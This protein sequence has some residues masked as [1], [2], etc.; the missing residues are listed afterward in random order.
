MTSRTVEDYGTIMISDRC[1]RWCSGNGIVGRNRSCG[2]GDA[3][4][5]L[6]LVAHDVL[7]LL[8]DVL[9]RLLARFCGRV[10]HVRPDTLR[11]LATGGSWC[12]PSL[13]IAT[14]VV[15]AVIAVIAVTQKISF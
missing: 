15:V 4:R 9:T 6:N 10:F 12:P 5:E 11:P 1:R 3:S 2:G 8:W 13:V 7:K 14:A